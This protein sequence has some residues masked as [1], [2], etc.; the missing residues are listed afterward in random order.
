VHGDLENNIRMAFMPEEVLSQSQPMDQNVATAPTQEAPQA[1]P[2][3]ESAPVTAADID[4]MDGKQ[5]REFIESQK[6]GRVRDPA[7]G[8][9]SRGVQ[10]QGQPAPKQ[11]YIIVKSEDGQEF[12]FRGQE[13]MQKS[14]LNSQRLLKKQW[15]QINQFNAERG[16]LGQ[17]KKNFEASQAK[18]NELNDY[19]RQLSQGARQTAA[20]HAPNQATQNVLSSL[21]MQP[22]QNPNELIYN[23]ISS[24][25]QLLDQERAQNESLRNEMTGVI[26]SFQSQKQQAAV[27]RDF[28]SLASEVQSIQQKYPEYK[29]SESFSKIEDVI[30]Q[31]GEEV[32]QTMVSP[33]D[34][35]KFSQIN[36][37]IE[38]YAGTPD[39]RIDMGNKKFQ[40]LE[41][42]IW[43]Y[44][45]R[46]GGGSA[47]IANAM[48]TGMQNYETVLKRTANSAT[49]LPNNLSSNKPT[50]IGQ[51]ELDRLMNMSADELRANPQALEK[52]NAVIEKI[53]GPMAKI[54]PVAVMSR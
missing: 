24:M 51:E 14:F 46:N 52:Y 6:A 16:Q 11:D 29:T 12:K 4:R 5:A 13:E 19:I 25:R 45:H 15:E 44:Q 18:I 23:E 1:Q 21:T 2:A 30:S 8:K 32:A 42:T 3:Q 37:L 9:F 27:Q 22:G 47:A 54:K 17:F 28:E 36:S 20:G 50:E 48:R 38:L 39:G 31:Y 53:A 49:T 40:D 41:E 35:E 10:N 34:W 7:T 43:I 26:T 33:E